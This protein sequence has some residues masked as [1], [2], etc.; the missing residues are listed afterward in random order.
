[1]RPGPAQSSFNKIPDRTGPRHP[2]DEDSTFPLGACSDFMNSDRIRDNLLS[3][4]ERI[5]AAAIAPVG[6]R[7]RS[8]WWRSPRSGPIELIRP[9]IEAGARDLGENYPQELWRKAE[10]LADPARSD[11]T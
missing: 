1:M 10:A 3:V 8:R 11:G 6:C 4:R 9:L 5:A 2:G 7:N